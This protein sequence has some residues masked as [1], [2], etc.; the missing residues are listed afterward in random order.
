MING[1]LKLFSNLTI[2]RDI[3]MLELTLM[4]FMFRLCCKD[5]VSVI[6]HIF[7]SFNCVGDLE[8]TIMVVMSN[9]Y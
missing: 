8:L 9:I 2:A 1:F 5:I 6:F 4:M 7:D 3:G